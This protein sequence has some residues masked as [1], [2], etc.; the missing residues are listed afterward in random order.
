MKVDRT[1][2]EIVQNIY[3]GYQQEDQAIRRENR[4]LEQRNR[5]YAAMGRELDRNPDDPALH[6]RIKQR[7]QTESGTREAAKAAMEATT[8]KGKQVVHEKVQHT[9]DDENLSSELLGGHDVME[10]EFD[11]FDEP[12]IDQ[13]LSFASNVEDS[14]IR[15]GNLKTDFETAST[16]DADPAAPENNPRVADVSPAKEP[17]NTI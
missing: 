10:G 16:E 9:A 4:E 6:D 8:I 2:A 11:L 17:S 14:P 3:G 15:G 1:D 7:L 12:P 13:S 5:K